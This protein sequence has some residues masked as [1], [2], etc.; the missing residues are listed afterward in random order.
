MEEIKTIANV[1][2]SLDG[3]GDYV[4]TGFHNTNLNLNAFTTEM[5]EMGAVLNMESDT[6]KV[7]G[8]SKK[9]LYS[10]VTAYY[11]KGKPLFAN[12]KKWKDKIVDEFYESKDM[13][14]KKDKDGVFIV[15]PYQLHGSINEIKSDMVGLGVHVSKV[16]NKKRIYVEFPKDINPTTTSTKKKKAKKKAVKNKTK[17][18][19]K[20]LVDG[21]IIKY[22][23]DGFEGFSKFNPNAKFVE[24]FGDKDA[25]IIYKKKKVLVDVRHITRKG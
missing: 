6:F 12:E 4:I 5:K 10:C 24:Y 9:R 16:V 20:N 23:G 7:K 22:I 14:F 15:D 18:D 3:S 25:M 1:T 19:N 2:I 8:V 11:G 17:I 21:D 13:I